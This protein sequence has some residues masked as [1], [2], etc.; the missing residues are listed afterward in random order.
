MNI[1]FLDVD[2]V[3]NCQTFYKERSHKDI[4]I[5]TWRI[6]LLNTLCKD[7]DIQVVISASMRKSHDLEELREFFKSYGA[8]FNIIG[9]T[10]TLRFPEA[11]RG[12]EIALWIKDNQELLDEKYYNFRSYVILD[13]DSD[14]LYKQRN[15][16]FLCDNYSGLTPSIVYRINYFFSGKY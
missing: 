1:L 8:T 6:S 4:E 10:P 11:C 5:D 12:N 3:L 7:N 15:H 16:L 2:G 13:D 14:M 9:L